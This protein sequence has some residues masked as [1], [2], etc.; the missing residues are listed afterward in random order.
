M[1]NVGEVLVLSGSLTDSTDLQDL[2]GILSVVVADQV[3]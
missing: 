2:V 3:G 1:A